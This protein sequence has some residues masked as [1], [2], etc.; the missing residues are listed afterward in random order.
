MLEFQV[1][2]HNLTES[3]LVEVEFDPNGPL[4]D[5]ELVLKIDKFGFSA[6]NITYGA[7]GE[8]LGYWQFFPPGG[9]QAGGWGMLPVW[10]FADV[11]A[12]AVDGVEAGERLFGYFPPTSFL[13]MANV[14]TSPFTLVDGAE[15]RAKL[16]PG[17]NT[18]RRVHAEPGY[19]KAMD[20]LRMLL[21]PLHITSF[22]LWDSLQDKKW[23]GAEQVV[24]VS[25]SSK[26]SLGLGYALADDPSSPRSIGLTSS[27]NLEWVEQLGIYR[28]VVSYEDLSAIDNQRSTVIVDMSG[29]TELLDKLQQH[30]GG[31][32]TFCLNVGLT[33]WDEAGSESAIPENKC[34][35]FFAPAHIQK[36]IQDWGSVGFEMKTAEF[37]LKTSKKSADWLVQEEHQGVS[38]LAG[39]YADVC[40]GV[41]GPER[42]LVIVL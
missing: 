34:E 10:G 7:I 36:R 4:T 11:I 28:S 21:W 3:R 32:L 14:K 31:N 5:G 42:G 16:P 2:K 18:Y 29:N 1:N 24:V 22:C 40:Q 20:N 39:L 35:F 23:L 8:Q 6:N 12:S 38:E 30:L 19:N 41:L 13:K 27:R 15:H 17:Y 33:H 25:A 26:T 9:D 37:M